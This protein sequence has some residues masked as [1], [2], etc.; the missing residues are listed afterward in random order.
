MARAQDGAV[1]SAARSESAGIGEHVWKPFQFSRSLF[2]QP[3]S[4]ALEVGKEGL[5]KHLVEIYSDELRNAPPPLGRVDGLA[6]LGK[7]TVMF[8][9]KQPA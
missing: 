1:L 3:K 5:E 8:N 4:G 2:V 7:P 6:S 9:A